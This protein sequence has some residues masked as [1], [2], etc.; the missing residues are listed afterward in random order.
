MPTFRVTV[1]EQVTYEFDMEA[2]A[3]PTYADAEAAWINT[4]DPIKDFVSCDDRQIANIE[5]GPSRSFALVHVHT[6]ATP[7]PVVT[8]KESP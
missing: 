6:G 1:V 2:E 5:S 8:T 4:G 3:A 7:Q